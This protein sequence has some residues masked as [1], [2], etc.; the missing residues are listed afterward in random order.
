MN[1]V[2]KVAV[3][4]AVVLVSSAAYAAGGNGLP[5]ISATANAT[6]VN[7]VLISQT[8]GLNFGTFA[9]SPTTGG[10]INSS[11]ATTGGVNAI[12]GTGATAA[13][14]AVTGSGSSYTIVGDPNVTLSD[15]VNNANP[16]M[17]AALT[18]PSSPRTLTGGNDSFNVSGVLTVAANQAAD[19]YAGTYNVSV[20]Y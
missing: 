17:T 18:Y 12:P 20:H 16:T 3:T 19:P 11:G 8:T 15:T 7:P 1:I 9:V 6:V 4:A 13:A 14:F 10:T 5:S 2:S